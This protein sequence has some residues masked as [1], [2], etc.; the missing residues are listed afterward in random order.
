MGDEKEQVSP[1]RVFVNSVDTYSSKFI[2]KFLA[3][4]SPVPSSGSSVD[5]DAEEEAQSAESD[6]EPPGGAFQVV[7]TT[8]SSREGKES[9][10]LEEYASPT[11]DQLLECLLECDVVVYNIS[12]NA[13]EE[14][15]EEGTWAITALHAE[16]MSF[17]SQK[18]F[19]LVSTVMTWAQTKPRDPDEPDVKLTEEDYRKRKPHPTFK[20]HLVLE[21]LVHKLGRAKRAKLTGYVVAAGLQYGKGENLFHYFFKA[22]WSMQFPEVPVFGP[23]TNYIPMIH[24]YDLGGVIHNIINLKPR[25]QYV[26][27][28]DDSKNTLE[29]IITGI[30]FALGPGKICKEEAV[31]MMA[32]RPEELDYL[33]I[34]LRLEPIL[35]KDTFDLRWVSQAGIV[36]NMDRV[37]KEYKHTRQL[38]PV[39]IFL[40]GP[41]AVGKTTVAEKLCKHYQVHHIMLKDVIEEKITQLEEMLSGGDDVNEEAVADAQNELQT[42]RDSMKNNAGRLTDHL[43]IQILQEKLNSQPC[44]NQGFVLDGFPKTYDQAKSIFSDEDTENQDLKSKAPVYNK[45]IT[46]EHVFALDAS[47]EFLER[48]VRD[49]P[50]GVVEKMRYTQEEFVARLAKY[51]QLSTTRETLLDYFDEL[52]IHP[53]H[54]EVN[55]DDPEYT[56]AIKRI[57]EVVGTPKNYGLSPEEQ[58]VE[59]RKLQEE[60]QQKLATEAAEAAEKKRRDEAEL[61]KLTAQREEWNR[62]LSEVKRQQEEL[63]EALS[64][65]LRNYLMKH[66]MP[67][68]S[69]AMI[70][71]CQVKPDN[72]VLFLADH[73]LRNI[74]KH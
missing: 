36:E 46:P 10:L 4:C 29:E 60:R 15:I 24:V 12:E 49:L 66:V 65:P 44:R 21:R 61:V 9:F 18:L 3:T 1:R 38:L 52:E 43:V 6:E 26:L 58:A 55:T 16:R 54:I 19:I 20:S 51:R 2:A 13:T 72:P 70:D 71:C 59:D 7:G 63:L 48:R 56:E 32:L 25:S 28:V 69:E 50:Q 34:D 17:T 14:Q 45:K 11:R 27:A 37:V 62:K 53:E 64:L 68:L 31:N 41:P 74:D 47:E 33:R 23:G 40:T 8:S 57:V 30:S 42:I 35:L 5:G 39:R 67:S 22:S 73:L